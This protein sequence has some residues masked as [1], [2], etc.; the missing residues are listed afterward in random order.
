MAESILKG[1]IMNSN[2]EPNVMVSPASPTQEAVTPRGT[3]TDVIVSNQELRE[4]NVIGLQQAPT[5][6]LKDALIRVGRELLVEEGLSQLSLRKVAKLAGVSH[7]APYRHF[8][9][10]SELLVYIALKDFEI[11][12]E[13]LEAA[14]NLYVGSPKAQLKAA[15]NAY[16]KMFLRHPEATEL[17]FG[18]ALRGATGFDDIEHYSKKCL[19]ILEEIIEEG[20]KTGCFES[21][22]S[23]TDLAVASWSMVH[24]LAMLRSG[25]QLTTLYSLEDEITEIGNFI[26]DILL[27]G[28]APSKSK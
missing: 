12:F 18:G 10:K 7:T 21:T 25:D 9:D 13:E 6:D 3:T 16:I 28:M 19:G 1:V 11:L 2:I 8:C 27:K 22:K 4:T 14:K 26:A 23:A 5:E 15:G 17:M 20:Q 24:G